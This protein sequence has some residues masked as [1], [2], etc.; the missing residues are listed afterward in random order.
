MY[1]LVEGFESSFGLEL[2]ST[3]HWVATE[4]QHSTDDR[5]IEYIYAW[6]PNKRKFLERQI[7]LALKLLRDKGWLKAGTSANSELT[8]RN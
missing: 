1:E 3:V 8:A 7:K 6:S 4:H 5:V 2:L